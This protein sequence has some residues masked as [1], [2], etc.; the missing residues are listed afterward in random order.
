LLWLAALGVPL[1]ALDGGSGV[2][3][4]LVVGYDALLL[5]GSWLEGRS[6]RTRPPRVERHLLDR[7]VSGR[8]GRVEL[9]VHNPHAR[10]VQVLLRDTPPPELA[11]VPAELPVKLAGFGRAR[12][13]YRMSPE[14]RG[15]YALGDVYAHLEGPLGLGAWRTSVP[16]SET[17]RVYPDVIGTRGDELRLRLRDQQHAG[18]RQVRQLGGGGEFAQ[19]REY[20]AGDPFRDLDWKSTAKR[21]RPVTRVLQHERSQTILLCLDVGRMMAG[22]MDEAAGRAGVTKLDHALDAA[23]MLAWFALRQGD[24]VGLVLFGATVSTYVPPGRGSAHYARLLDASYDAQAQSTFVDFRSLVSFVRTRV[25][26][27]ALVVLFSD[28]LDDE[29]AMPLAD[30]AAVLRQKHLPLC[31]TLE[32]PLAAR[33]ADAP[34]TDP[35]DVYAR[36]AAADLL[37]DRERVKAHLT[38]SGVGLVEASASELALSTVRRYLEIKAKHAL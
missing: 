13:P 8:A 35:G 31:V 24:Y 9:V 37:S 36:A 1:A 28:L 38:K 34:A 4:W 17:V 32:E 26:K 20:V 25:K 15:S 12:L 19:L 14:R 30:S 29:H 6:L 23:L 2:G 27:R 21:R 5:L 18:S 22:R 10:P 11:L 16:A 7:L 33:L 3:L